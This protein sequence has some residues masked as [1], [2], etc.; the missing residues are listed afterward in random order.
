MSRPGLIAA[1]AYLVLAVLFLWQDSRAATPSTWISL[2][3][4][5]PFLATFPV[6][7]PLAMFG[8]EPDL[9]SKANVALLLLATAGLIYWVVASVSRYLAR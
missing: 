3:S 7:A 1:C 6:S 9:T 8:I 4:I 5:A 2:K